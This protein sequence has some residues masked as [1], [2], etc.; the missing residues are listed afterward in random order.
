MDYHVIDEKLVL[1]IFRIS[2]P[3]GKE[4][5]M[6]NYI[7]DFL[8]KLN[9]TYK[10]DVKGNIYNLTVKDRPVLS[11]HMDTVEKTNDSTLMKF[12]NIR[13]YKGKKFVKGYG[14][15]GGDD[16]CGIYIML[17]MLETNKNFNFIFSVS[18]EIGCLGIQEVVKNEDFSNVSYG[19]ILDRRYSGDIICG[20]NNYGTKEFED[21]LKEVGKEFGYSPVRGSV[22]DANHIRSKVSCANLSVGY[23]EPH[24]TKEYV[25]LD[26]LSK[27]FSFV[28]KTM[29]T[30]VKRYEPS[31][32]VE[33]HSTDYHYNSRSNNYSTY[34]SYCYKYDKKDLIKLS[35]NS[36]I[37]PDC[38]KQVLEAALNK[39]NLA[40]SSIKPIVLDFINK[41]KGIE[42]TL[43]LPDTTIEV[44]EEDAQMSENLSS[45]EALYDCYD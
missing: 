7:K 15:I 43:M 33:T 14:I 13:K 40:L 42:Q 30:L 29:A 34:C 6:R 26:D 5:A 3:S 36:K 32:F 24:S 18:E 16:K 22:S 2:S 12:V 25:S 10:E 20:L 38:L 27:A 17:K 37:C 39:D 45:V 41:A 1:D 9:V 35:L 21:D 31:K 28:E 19:L 8:N 11:S 4:D 23:Y 44:E